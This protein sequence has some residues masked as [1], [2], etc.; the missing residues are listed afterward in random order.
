MKVLDEIVLE[1]DARISTLEKK[2]ASLENRL[3]ALEKLV[4]DMA[5]NQTDGS[6]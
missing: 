6:R 4:S 1:K 5:A 2:S 3:T